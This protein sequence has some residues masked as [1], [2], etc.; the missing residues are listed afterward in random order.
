MAPKGGVATEKKKVDEK[1]N[2]KD[3]KEDNTS[4]P[5]EG[6][7]SEADQALKWVLSQTI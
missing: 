2:V 1:E 7:L 5:E 6:E 3:K 4:I